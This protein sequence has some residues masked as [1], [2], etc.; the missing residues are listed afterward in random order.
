[1]SSEREAMGSS[2]VVVP[3]ASV[4]DDRGL[5][6]RVHERLRLAIFRVGDAVYAIDDRCP[7]QGASLGEGVLAGTVVTCPWHGFMVDVTTGGCPNHA[8]LRVRTYT[9]ER[10]GDMV[11]VIIPPRPAPPAVA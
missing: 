5:V 6:V 4:P 10:E 3:L 1:M 7:H 9:V 11:R 2:D 8:L